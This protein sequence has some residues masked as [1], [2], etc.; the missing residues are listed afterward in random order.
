MPTVAQYAARTCVSSVNSAP[1]ATI[2]SEV[3]KLSRMAMSPAARLRQRVDAPNARL[4]PVVTAVTG[5]IASVTTAMVAS[6]YAMN[7]QPARITASATTTSPPM[8]A[9]TTAI[10]ST[11]TT[12]VMNVSA[13]TSAR[14]SM[15]HGMNA[16]TEMIAN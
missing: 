6:E 10:A 12:A 15:I 5:C 7:S 13:N 8:T 14:Y 11:F 4:K 3:A 9:T 16:S 1:T 2:G